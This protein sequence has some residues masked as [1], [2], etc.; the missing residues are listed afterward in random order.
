MRKRSSPR[1][2]GAWS[3]STP[4]SSATTGTRGS[5]S[6]SACWSSP[7]W[8]PVAVGD[9]A[10]APADV[11][12]TSWGAGRDLRTWS[13]PSAGGIAWAQR[14]AE[15]QALG[16]GASPRALRELLA[17]QSSDWAFQIANANAGDYPRERARRTIAAFTH[18]LRAPADPQL[19]NLAPALA[20]WAFVQP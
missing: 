4:S 9:A 15:L 10:P 17:L 8:S 11:P 14:S 2:D 6:S 13:A 20:D 16:G 12:P 19:R 3:R 18:A 1:S 7:T 5:C